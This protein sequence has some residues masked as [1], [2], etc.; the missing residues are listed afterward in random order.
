MKPVDIRLG[1]LIKTRWGLA[2]VQKFFAP[3]YIGCI[4]INP[5][6]DVTQF[7]QGDWIY[8]RGLDLDEAKIIS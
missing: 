6:T 8:L 1:Q 5:S 7:Q 4:I 3:A 2:V